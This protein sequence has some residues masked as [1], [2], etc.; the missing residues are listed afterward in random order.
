[1][2]PRL[3]VIVWKYPWLENVYKSNA[4]CVKKLES[5][6]KGNKRVEQNRETIGGHRF[7]P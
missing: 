6:N 4:R 1:M 5:N 7:T 3:V 2:G